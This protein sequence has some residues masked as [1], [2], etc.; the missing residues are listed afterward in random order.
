MT[1]CIAMGIAYSLII[2]F[3]TLGPFLI[4]DVMEYSAA[5]FGK[6]AISLG[7]AFLPAPILGRKLLDHY[8]V[9]KIFFVV[10]HARLYSQC[11]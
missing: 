9:G 4:Q 7:C 3:N 5:Y 1:L 11:L 8:S 2:S 6:L 10:I